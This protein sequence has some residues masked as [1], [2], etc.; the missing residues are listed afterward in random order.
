M[1]FYLSDDE[2]D[3]KIP[4]ILN[5]CK[6]LSISHDEKL[7]VRLLAKYNNV[8]NADK[9]IDEAEYTEHLLQIATACD[10]PVSC[11]VIIVDPEVEELQKLS[12]T[13]TK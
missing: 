11:I 10:S 4:D 8:E 5:D 3:R 6:T 2:N 1:T 12:H 13:D 9:Y 7:Y